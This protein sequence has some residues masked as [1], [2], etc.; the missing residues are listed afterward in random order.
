MEQASIQ[1]Y[2]SAIGDVAVKINDPAD[3]IYALFRN[4]TNEQFLFIGQED[5]LDYVPIQTVSHPIIRY[6]NQLFLL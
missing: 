3:R 2:D 5:Y 6:I 4:F 1:T